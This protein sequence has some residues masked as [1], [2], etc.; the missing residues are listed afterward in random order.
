MTFLVSDKNES[1]RFDYEN[2]LHSQI[3]KKKADH[4]YRVFKRVTRRAE[5]FPIATNE[6]T[7]EDITVWC[8]NDYLGMSWH[9]KV[10]AAVMYVQ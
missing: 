10:Q 7:G 4:T 5:E 3:E 2:F 8:S 6:V 9:P 1:T